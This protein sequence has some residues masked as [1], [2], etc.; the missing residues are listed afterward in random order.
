MKALAITTVLFVF[1]VVGLIMGGFLL[2]I[3]AAQ[4]IGTLAFTE[5][6]K[7]RPST[8]DLILGGVLALA[9][10]AAAEALGFFLVRRY[11]SRP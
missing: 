4:S 3:P 10:S 7:A 6:F 8:A 2:Y 5:H 9:V 11:R 1:P